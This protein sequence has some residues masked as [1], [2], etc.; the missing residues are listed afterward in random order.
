MPES[1]LCII[2]LLVTTRP[3]GWK[4]DLKTLRYDELEG[5][6]AALEKLYSESIRLFAASR[7]LVNILPKR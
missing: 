3:V 6:H 4:V 5:K 1:P 2:H 7:Q